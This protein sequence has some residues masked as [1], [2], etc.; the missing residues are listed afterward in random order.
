MDWDID[1]YFMGPESGHAKAIKKVIKSLRQNLNIYLKEV[2][3]NKVPGTYS[4]Q[5]RK[6]L[7]Y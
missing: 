5:G 7:Y 1:V 2:E 6:G 3:W 4:P